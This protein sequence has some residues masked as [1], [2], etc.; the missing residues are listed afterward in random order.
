MLLSPF[1]EPFS[2]S[3]PNGHSEKGASGEEG[4]N[5]HASQNI[6]PIFEEWFHGNL[7]RKEV[8]RLSLLSS[9]LISGV[10]FQWMQ[11]GTIS[12]IIIYR[13]R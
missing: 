1:V 9:M 12:L 13:S 10:K 3:V 6:T 11:Y 7:S 8:S 5:G 2:A 4:S